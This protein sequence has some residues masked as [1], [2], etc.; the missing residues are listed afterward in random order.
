MLIIILF[1]FFMFVNVM[2]SKVNDCDNDDNIYN[3]W[4]C[5]KI[6]Y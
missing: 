5:M 2:Y 3:M 6:S 4:I 1:Y